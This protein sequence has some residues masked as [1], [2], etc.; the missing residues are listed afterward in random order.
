M[1]RL[2]NM[3]MIGSAGRNAG[4]TEFACRLIRT[5]SPKA[6]IVGIKVTTILEK[7]GLCPRGGKGCGVC[8]SLDSEY[9]ITDEADAPPDKDTAR[10]VAAG[11]SR[12]YWLRCLKSHLREGFSELLEKVS[13]DALLVCES[14]SLRHVVRPGVF[15]MVRSDES[16]SMKPSAAEVQRLAD[17]SVIFDGT[18]FDLETSRV[19]IDKGAWGLAEKATA[20]IMAG[21]KSARM[22]TDKALLPINGMPMIEN[23]HHDLR[24]HFEEV[25]VSA[26]DEMSYGFLGVRVIAD[27]LE[28][29]GPLAG[30][31]S[32][33]A[34]SKSEL[35]FVVTCDIPE[36]NMPFARYMLREAEGHDIVVPGNGS[37]LEPLYAVYRRNTVETMNRLLEAGERRVRALFDTCRTR[38]V[39]RV[40]AD[41]TGN[42]NTMEEYLSYVTEADDTV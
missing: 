31:A 41:V 6:E 29:Q 42:L 26:A 4:K 7:D 24:P 20:V 23:V 40:E 14:N 13:A 21:G 32:A 22:G 30:M 16:D 10:L 17:R 28:G 8:S 3:F 36:I 5:F 25:I 37:C 35:N 12:V 15:V 11:A 34:A 19:N 33:L 39:D 1:I 2:P 38:V 27:R 9:C 18:G